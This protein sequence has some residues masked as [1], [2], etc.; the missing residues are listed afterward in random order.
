MDYFN[1]IAECEGLS[2]YSAKSIQILS[3]INALLSDYSRM[4]EQLLKNMKISLNNLTNEINKPINSIYKLKY[5]SSFEKNTLNII[6]YLKEALSK[7]IRENDLLQSEIVSPLN[8][9]IKHINNQNILLFNEFKSCIDEI[10]KQKK[11]CD[12]SKDNY[13]NCGKQI[14]ILAEKLNNIGNENN[15]ESKELNNNLNILKN[16]FQKYYI[17]YKDNVN[18]TNKLYEEKNK[19]YF[20]Y[21]L[22]L[23]ETEDSKETFM[24]FYFE[25]FDNYLK[26]KLKIL[27]NFQTGFSTM[28]PTP[29]N[30]KILKDK[31]RAEFSEQ[32]NNFVVDEEKKIRVKN[33]E[34]IDY[35]SYKKQLSALIN[36]NRMYLKEDTK[37]N[38]INF[39]PQ[40]ILINTIDSTSLS[41]FSKK[42]GQEYIFNQEE[43]ILI[44]NIFL[45]EEIDTFKTE[46]L[47]SKIKNNFEYAQNI[48]DKVLERYTSSI[49]VQILNKNNFI[50]FGKMING[51]ILNEEIQKNLFEINFAILYISEKTFYQKEDNPFYKKYL[52]KLLSELNE[53]IR[54][55]EYW[56]KLLF[57]RIQMTLEEEANIRTKK[58]LKEEKKKKMIEEKNKELT[59]KNDKVDKNN[60]NFNDKKRNSAIFEKGK[61]IFG[62]VGNLFS[63]ENSGLTAE[64]KEKKEK[65]NLRKKEIYNEV[66]NKISSDVAIKIIKDFIVHFS[67]FCVES[68]DVIDI[69]SDI[70]NKFKIVGEEKKIKYFISIFNSNMYSI[71]NTKFKIIPEYLNKNKNNFSKFMN[72]NYMKGIA[73]KNNKSLILLNLM[74]YLPFND[75]K[76]IILVNK[77]TYNLVLKTLYS[78]L[79]INIDENIPEEYL[80]K[81]PIPNV[82]KNP[83]LRIKIWKHLLNFKNDINYK[84][85]IIDIHKKEN[86]QECFDLIEMDVKRMW[87]E[88]N[89]DEIKKSLSNILCALG[90][91]HPKIGYSQ[92][93]NCIASLLYDIC[94]GEE[95]AFN[96][97]N[98]LLASTDYGDLYYNDL[99]R[100]NKYFYVFER[101]IFI[102]LPEV[103]LHLI[104][105]KI[106]PK[107]FISPWF[108]TLF[109]N[110]YKNIKGKGKPKVLI[111]I[112][113]SFIIEGWRAINKIGLCLM[114]HFEIKILNMDTD[115]LLHFLINDIINYDFFKNANYE[116]LRIIYDNLQIE[117]GLIENIENEY[118]I[119]NSISTNNNKENK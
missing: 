61:K 20:S 27:T 67:C 60:N 110:A 42:N 68:Y 15:N 70:T 71:K 87:F 77:S 66:Y 23:K 58:I 39:N 101:L 69:I 59:P 46:Q 1:F 18:N 9:F 44:E 12:I 57:I 47:I 83:E 26:S 96:I 19:E 114:K 31:G 45:I 74:K 56:L 29:E 98:C 75:Y 52:C 32:L 90:Y 113:D 115:E 105:T 65:E 81:N 48:I 118:E 21:I 109:T 28:I 54:R 117:N 53:F 82:W 22:K 55:K 73:N 64:E 104:S 35:D 24:N 78:N 11:K 2:S 116:S 34:F 95:E 37:N 102:Y 62:V 91:L 5:I 4:K 16:K 80:K 103:Y 119:K 10:Y 6:S 108:I 92:G 86:K 33:E 88:E 30:E 14:T 85:L 51:V 50:K 106:S 84:Q 99:K 25:K 107:F 79:L 38:R 72:E 3:S 94:G 112:L 13:I 41:S 7:E 76:N 17:D 89:I 40:E 93:M 63:R 49:G 8:S 43:N 100:L 97:F 111:W 36:Q